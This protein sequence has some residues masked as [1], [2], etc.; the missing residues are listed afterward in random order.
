MSA[1]MIIENN[2]RRMNLL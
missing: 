2:F 1:I